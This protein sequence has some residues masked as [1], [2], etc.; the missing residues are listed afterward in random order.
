VRPPFQPRPSHPFSMAAVGPAVTGRVVLRVNGEPV[1]E[2]EFNAAF[3]QVPEQLQPQFASEAGKIAFAEQLIRLKLLEQQAER[4]GLTSDPKI[5]GEIAAQSAQTLANAAAEK[6]IARP[7]EAEVRKYY[8]D[9]KGRFESIDVS[10]ILI[11]YAGGAVP[12][13]DGGPAPPETDAMNKA[14]KV[15]DDLVKGA[16]FTEEAKKYSDDV[17]SA[18]NG[19]EL[20]Q[21]APGQ[22]PKELEARVFHIPTGRFSGPIPSQYGIH[23]FRVNSRGSVPFDKIKAGL[24]QRVRQQDLENRVEALRR[25]AKVDWDQKFF[26]DLKNWQSPPTGRKPS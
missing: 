21:L 4:L 22:L 10:H 7:T 13:R 15:Y 14:L 3:Q 19:G 25:G 9:N 17:N 23:I 1:T 24:A 11:A 18:N 16:N 12:P 8:T 6:M 2:Q 20:G 26:P 5:Q